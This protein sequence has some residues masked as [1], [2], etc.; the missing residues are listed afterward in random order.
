MKLTTSQI[1]DFEEHAVWQEILVR[2][3]PQLDKAH[4]IA[5]DKRDMEGA[6]AAGE[7]KGLKVVLELTEQLLKEAAED[8]RS[9]KR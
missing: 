9:I 1:R 4:N 2:M 3:T 7:Y 8:E 5:I 6:M